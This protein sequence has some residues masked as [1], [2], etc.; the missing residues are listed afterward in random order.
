MP[1]TFLRQYQSEF[2]KNLRLAFPIMLGQLGQI[3]VNLAD[4]LMVGRLGSAALAAVSL[5]NA[6]FIIFFVIGMG[7]SFA[8]PPLIAEAD[9]AG[10]S[11]KM[12]QYFKHSLV[13][14]LIYSLIALAIILVGIP[15][16]HNL[17]QDPEVV[18]LAI[19]Y[20]KLCAWS[21]IPYMIFQTFR[22]YSDGR[23]E[24]VPP[25]IA[26]IS[27]NAVNIILNFALIFGMWGFPR[28]GVSGAAMAS[29]IA[30]ISMVLLIVVLLIQWKGIWEQIRHADYFKYQRIIFKKILSLGIPTS[31]QMFFEVTAFAGAAILMGQIGKVPQ[32]AHQI[33]I[34][35]ASM[36]FLICTGIAMAG[37]I[38]VGNQFGRRNRQ[39]LRNAGFAAIILVTLIMA[40]TALIFVLS[41]NFLPTLYIQEEAVIKIA[42]TLLIWAALF[43][44]PDGVQVTSLGALRGLQDVITP[45]LITFVAYWVFGLPTSYLAAFI[46]DWGPG[47]IWFGLVLGLSLS[48]TLLTYRFHVKT[49]Q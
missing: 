35:L 3:T 5:A 38:R 1:L 31:M 12:S 45:T 48:A 17:K 43:Q 24:T 20:L 41:R 22:N 13:N 25:M 23:S 10:E 21:L 16:L 29:L 15:L 7:L 14:N 28:L 44:I 49:K 47:G 9:G 2:K 46:F 33:A 42:A 34:N 30:R 40:S 27:G 26:M 11:K 8:L 32:A 4:N 36:T 37:T 6:I 39:A 18:Q 19:P